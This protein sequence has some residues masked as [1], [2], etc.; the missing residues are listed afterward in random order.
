VSDAE[1]LIEHEGSGL[2]DFEVRLADL[3]LGTLILYCFTVGI[4]AGAVGD[5]WRQR[6]LIGIAALSPAMFLFGLLLAFI[7]DVGEQA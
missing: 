5:T 7:D 4:A 6:S 1:R 3:E 2:V